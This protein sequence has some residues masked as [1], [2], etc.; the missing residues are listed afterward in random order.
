MTEIVI[1]LRCSSNLLKCNKMAIILDLSARLCIL[2][3]YMLLIEI[4][5]AAK[6][7]GNE[8]AKNSVLKK[9]QAL[10]LRIIYPSDNQLVM[11]QFLDRGSSRHVR[12]RCQ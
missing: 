8:L 11:Y 9:N 4:I 5:G 7:V 12:K 10:Q 2:Y 6:R 3:K 1:Y